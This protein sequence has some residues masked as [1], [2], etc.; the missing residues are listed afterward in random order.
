MKDRDSQG[1]FLQTHNPV[2]SGILHGA[3]AVGKFIFGG[4]TAKVVDLT[5]ANVE[6]GDIFKVLVQVEGYVDT[7]VSFTA[8]AITVANVTAGLTALLAALPHPIT[9]VDNATKVTVTA[10][11]PGQPF[12]LT[13]STVNGGAADTQ[14]LTA[15][16]TT[17]NGTATG[18]KVGAKGKLNRVRIAAGTAPA[19]AA[20]LCDLVNVSNGF[21]KSIITLPDG[22]D[23]ALDESGGISA[24]SDD[25]L[26]CRVSQVGSGT[27][28]SDISVNVEAEIPNA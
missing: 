18:I 13:P 22:A 11:N 21:L 26:Y 28:G 9:P 23:F 3:A 19:G 12:I 6:I 15:T 17:P 27:A 14:T 25:L 24:K 7:T 10:V 8:T 2:A 20:L 16:T 5:P 1:R 4:G